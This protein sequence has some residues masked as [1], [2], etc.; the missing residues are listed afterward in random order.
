M[1]RRLPVPLLLCLALIAT[2]SEPHVFNIHDYGATGDGATLDTA[3]INKTIEA[4]AGDGGGQVFFPAGRYLSG[5]IHLRS[6]TSLFLSAGAV[7]VGTTNLAQYE[8][9][10]VPSFM[11]EA[12]WGKWNRGLVIGEGLEDVTIGGPGLIDGN[13]VF[14]PTGEEHRRGPHTITFVNCR[15]FMLRDFSIQDAANYAIFFQVSD[16]VEVRNVKITGGWDG[17]HFRGAADRWCQNVNIINCQFYTG[18]DSIAGRY[19]NN[20]VISGCVLNSACNGLRLIGPATHLTVNDCLFYGPGREP[21]RSS[22]RHNMLSGIILQPGAWDKCDGP[23]DDVFLANN[24]MR[25][26][27]SPITI[28]TRPGNPVGRVTVSGLNATGV[29]RAA[30]SVESWSDMPITNVVIR[31]A[32]IEF[33]GGGQAELATKPVRHPAVDVRP[34]PGWGIYARNVEQLTLQDVR[35]DLAQDDRRPVLAAEQITRLELDNFRY[36]H[37]AGVPEALLLT[38]VASL[39]R[40]E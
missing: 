36:P 6:H 27:A 32:S 12:R 18:D 23:L 21:H 38:N 35:L 2:A 17:V 11:P 25:D 30:L 13:K 5:T 16:E 24:S 15:R 40:G 34:L 22:A 3:A 9:P 26:V 1:K 14:D 31:G 37:V 33:T 7:L 19:W 20:V 10:A 39:K 4:C 29:Y 28:W 8:A